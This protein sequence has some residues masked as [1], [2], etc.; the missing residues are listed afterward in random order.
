MTSPEHNEP[1]C[2]CD[3]LFVDHDEDLACMVEGCVC[4]YYESCEDDLS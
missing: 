2:M 4:A 1:P 3:H